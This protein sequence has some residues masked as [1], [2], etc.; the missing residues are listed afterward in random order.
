[1]G[2][3]PIP[4]RGEY[5][6]LGVLHNNYPLKKQVGVYRIIFLGDSVTHRRAYVDALD[7]RLAS[8]IPDRRFE[9]WNAAVEGYNAVQS[10]R[11]FQRSGVH[12]DAD[13]CILGFHL[14]DFTSTRVSYQDGDHLVVFTPESS[15]Y[16]TGLYQEWLFTHSAL[17]RYLLRASYGFLS[18]NYNLQQKIFDETLESL[19]RLRN[20]SAQHSIK[21][22]VVIFPYI[23]P[24]NKYS[25]E[26]R[27]NYEGLKKFLKQEQIDYLDTWPI[28]ERVGL[29]NV[30]DKR[31]DS[32][33]STRPNHLHPNRFGH[34]LVGEALFNYIAMLFRKEG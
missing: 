28:F 31:K 33:T 21:L 11:W 7:R 26:Q 25:Q 23:Q 2:Y 12:Y 30:R 6:K 4:G 15:V 5:N 9:L 17:Y 13:L 10:I 29:E 27:M 18:R 8:A 1:M 32:L 22:I 24:M 14:N 20:I 3:E 34:E 16:Q 19:S